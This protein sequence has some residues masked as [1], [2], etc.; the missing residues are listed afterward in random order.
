MPYENTLHHWLRLTPR[1]HAL[2]VRTDDGEERTVNISPNPRTR[3]KT[4]EEAVRS[5]QASHVECLNEKGDVLR[6]MRLR[7]DEEDVA[8]GDPSKAV[9]KARSQQNRENAQMLDAFGRH[10]N[11]AFQHG[12]AAANTGQEHLV[13]LVETLTSH[14]SAAIVSIHNLSGH[15]ASLIQSGGTEE[16]GENP[17]AGLLKALAPVLMAQMGHAAPAADPANG[18]ARKEAKP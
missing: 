16:D 5:L 11:A 1:P 12:A 18:K 6:A 13:T 4:A 8:T 17:N 2:R 14:L 7:E 15:V 9:E 3:W 10:L